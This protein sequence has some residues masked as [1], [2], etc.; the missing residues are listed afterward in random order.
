PSI[1]APPQGV[2]SFTVQEITRRKKG[3]Q[4]DPLNDRQFCTP[5]SSIH[6]TENHP[7]LMASAHCTSCTNH[8]LPPFLLR[9]LMRNGSFV[10]NKKRN[11]KGG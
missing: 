7:P 6:P 5:R 2:F 3:S 1:K 9:F 10:R 4:E 8:S 11:S